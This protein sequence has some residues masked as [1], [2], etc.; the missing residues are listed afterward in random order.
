MPTTTA[1][2]ISLYYEVHG[3]G[4]NLV[5]IE[6]I[7]YH[8][9]MW[10]RQ[11]PAFAP[12]FRTLIYDNRGVG[13]S[14]MP[15]GPYTHEQNADDLAG[16]LDSIGWD[17]AHILGISMGGFIAQEFALKYSQRVDRL[18]LVATAFG[19][20]NMVPLPPEAIK[21]LT[22]DPTLSPEE[23]IRQAMP[24]AFSTTDWPR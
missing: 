23:K 4:P 13:R 7:G 19:G 8:T 9:W 14:D 11:I 21:A 5:L 17:R 16:L 2:G 3:E 10:Y 18:V 1:N 24:V 15:P 22:P 6:G 20:P 12:H